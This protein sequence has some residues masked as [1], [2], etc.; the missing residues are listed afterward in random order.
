MTNI[1]QLRDVLSKD[2]EIFFEHQQEKD[3]IY[4]AAFTSMDPSDLNAF[5]NHWEKILGDETVLIKTIISEDYVVGHVLSYETDSKPE[6][7]YWIGQK[8]WGKGIATQALKIF[9][10]V[11]NTKRTIYA[12]V[13]KDNLGSIHVLTKCGFKTIEETHGFANAR[14]AEIAEMLLILTG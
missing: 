10:A 4:M 14:G 6:V 3:A 13:A 5:N 7:S 11:V 12:R 9:L 2:L 1:I 8:Y